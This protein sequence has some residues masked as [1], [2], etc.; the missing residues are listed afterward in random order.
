MFCSTAGKARVAVCDWHGCSTSIIPFMRR[1]CCSSKLGEEGEGEG[2]EEEEPEKKLMK[3][4]II[5]LARMVYLV[6]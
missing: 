2:E 4:L 3:K 5:V 1:G 6:W